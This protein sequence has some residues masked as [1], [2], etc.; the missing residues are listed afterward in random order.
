SGVRATGPNSIE[1]TL[2]QPRG[3]FLQELTMSTIHV[4]P[5]EVVE[6]LGP[7]FAKKPVGTGA[8]AV[9]EWVEGQRISLVKNPTWFFAPRPYLDEVEYQIGV[10]P[11]VSLLR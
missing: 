2:K 9:K 6:Q 10:E 3:V 1:I 7:D 4:V 8:F 11:N 5:K